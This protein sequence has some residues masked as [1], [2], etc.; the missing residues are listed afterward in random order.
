MTDGHV[1]HVD[2]C[3]FTP[4]GCPPDARNASSAC[5]LVAGGVL[6]SLCVR[7]HFACALLSVA[8]SEAVEAE[9]AE[10]AETSEA[11]EAAADTADAVDAAEVADALNELATESCDPVG[12]LA[13]T[14]ALCCLRISRNSSGL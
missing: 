5:S 2:T 1:L 12:S 6:C 3:A 4:L 9:T 14:C 7:V 8:V 13:T 11:T 10:A